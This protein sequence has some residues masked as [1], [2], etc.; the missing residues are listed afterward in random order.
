M[1]QKQLTTKKNATTDKK[2]RKNIVNKI[3]CHM[4]QKEFSDY[5]DDDKK[6][7]V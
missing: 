1:Q 5:N 3:F 4:S 2:K 7:K 6:F